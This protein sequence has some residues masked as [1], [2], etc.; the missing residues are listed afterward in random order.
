MDGSLSTPATDR[1]SS[2]SGAQREALAEPRR[3][4]GKV[5]YRASLLIIVGANLML[6]GLIGLASMHLFTR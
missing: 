6:W 1:L 4:V 5:S 2:T 3:D